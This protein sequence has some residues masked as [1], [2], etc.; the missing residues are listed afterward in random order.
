[1]LPCTYCKKDFFSLLQKY[2]TY[3][4]TK[5]GFMKY[6]SKL[7]TL[8]NLKVKTKTTTK[9][10]KGVTTTTRKKKFTDV[11]IIKRSSGCACGG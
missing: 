3:K 4:Q 5:P 9:T 6:I 11:K 10:K 7:H 2:K 8:V 1:M